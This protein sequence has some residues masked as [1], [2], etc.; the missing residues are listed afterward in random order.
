LIK[1]FRERALGLAD[2]PESGL[3]CKLPCTRLPR[4]TEQPPPTPTD[5]AVPDAPSAAPPG[6]TPP[7]PTSGGDIP[8]DADDTRGRHFGALARHPLTLIGGGIL[9]VATGVALAVG[10]G[11]AIG[12]AGAAVVVL[13]ILLIV[14]LLASS[15][16]QSD[17]FKAYAQGHSLQLQEGRGSMPPMTPLL[18]RGDDR[19]T[20]C[21]MRGT[22]PGGEQGTLALYT[23]EDTTTDSNGDRSTTYM[24]FTLMA[25]EVP[26]FAP[27]MHE[28]FGQ[29]RVG[30]RFLDGAEDVFRKRQRVEHESEVVDKRYEI[31]CGED[32]DMNRARQVL[33][34]QFLVWLSDHSPEAFAFECVAGYLVC[35]VKGHKKSAAELD[36]FC[37]GAAGVAKRLREEALE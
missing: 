36:Q 2:P 6:A 33:S 10:V 19:Y 37:E 22:L 17:F 9:V 26:E 34:P 18:Q 8:L 12:A 1:R 11:P 21:T 31:F 30:F 5:P 35:N 24:H 29:R 25:C 23:Y 4:M 32:D 15:R 20:Q 27:F 3:I 16:A 13:L 7:P 14:W 28:L